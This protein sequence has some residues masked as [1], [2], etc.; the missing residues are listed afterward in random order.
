MPFLPAR[1][2]VILTLLYLLV[3]VSLVQAAPLDPAM[4]PSD[5]KWLLHFDVEKARD[6][7]LMQKWQQQMEGKEWYRDKVAEM[8]EAYGWN[9]AKDLEGV[10]MYDNEYARFNGVLA[11]HVRNIDAEK[12]AARFQ[13]LHP[14]AKTESYR[15]RFISTWTTDSPYRGEH[16]VSGCL[17][18]NSLMLIGN[19]PQK[20]KASIDVI[21]G[22][23]PALQ[24]SSPL[25]DSFNQDALLACRAIAVPEKY[26]SK[27]RCPVLQRCQSATMFF[28]ANNDSIQFKYDLEA[29]NEELASKM[30]GAISGMRAMM[31]MK[32]D[33]DKSGKEMLNAVQIT[34]EEN[35]LLVEWQGKTEDVEK[36]CQAMKGRKW[37]KYNWKQSKNKRKENQTSGNEQPKNKSAEDLDEWIKNFQ[38]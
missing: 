4:I 23:A 8:V 11:L 9:P 3:C 32:M 29:N 20:I 30:K 33:K 7:N 34:R 5:T 28:D 35:H 26:Q 2:L 13:K 27:T 17:I 1:P 12:I 21:D 22:Q 15:D 36:L 14:E 6:W 16:S 19:T 24:D 18:N 38:L 31:G 10:S 37:D 25:L